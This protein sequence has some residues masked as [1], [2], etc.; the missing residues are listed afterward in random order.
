LARRS[1]AKAAAADVRTDAAPKALA[2]GQRDQRLRGEALDRASD[3]GRVAAGHEVVV[4]RRSFERGGTAGDGVAGG[5]IAGR[6]IAARRTAVGRGERRAR[7]DRLLAVAVESHQCRVLE[8]Q[9]DTFP[10]PRGVATQQCRR[11]EQHTERRPVGGQLDAPRRCEDVRFEPE[12]TDQQRVGSGICLVASGVRVVGSGVR[13]T[14]TLLT[15]VRW[16]AAGRSASHS[17]LGL[18]C[19]CSEKEAQAVDCGGS[20]ASTE[21]ATECAQPRVREQRSAERIE[22]P[23]LD[24]VLEDLECQRRRDQQCR[25]QRMNPGDDPH[26]SRNRGRARRRVGPAPLRP[27][28]EPPAGARRQSAATTSLFGGRAAALDDRRHQGQLALH[29]LLQVVD[30]AA[31]RFHELRGELLAHLRQSRARR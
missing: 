19:E 24:A 18:A 4:R 13:V 1:V 14:G 10:P 9:Q 11:E 5:G 25:L 12:R 16:K 27:R 29:E 3:D 30:R 15:R 28:P 26:R 21:R 17:D 7:R 20:P 23:D 8:A 31:H 6:N 2:Q 22:R